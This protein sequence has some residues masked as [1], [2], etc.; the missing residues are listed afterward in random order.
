MKTR[1]PFRRLFLLSPL[2]GFMVC[3]WAGTNQ[4]P[5]YGYR[6][7]ETFPHDPSAYTQGLLFHEGYLYESTGRRGRSEL[8]KVELKSGA[9]V[10]SS[11]LPDNIFGEGLALLDERLYQLSWQA[12]EARVYSLDDFEELHRFSYLGEGWGLTAMEGLLVMSN[13]SSRLLF[14]D[15]KTF[16]TV[17]TLQVQSKGAPVSR[18]NELEYIEGEIWANVWRSDKI[19]RIDPVTGEVTGWID[20][21]GLLSETS[22][23]YR[24]DV[25]NGIA[26]DKMEQRIFVT[27]KL[28]PKLFQIELTLTPE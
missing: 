20:L 2:L 3:A 23:M 16:K 17:R 13:G 19:A 10:H 25:L 28:W 22:L 7:V 14:I 15:P 21:S 5:V 26:Y 27:G 6:V 9:V 11:K 4:I 18:L 12:G 24:V 8:R 1:L